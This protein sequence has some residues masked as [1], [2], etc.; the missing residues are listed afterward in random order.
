MLFKLSIIT[1]PFRIHDLGLRI[2]QGLINLINEASGKNELSKRYDS[3]NAFFLEPVHG[4]DVLEEAIEKLEPM[5]QRRIRA[6]EDITI[7]AEELA[8]EHVYDEQPQSNQVHFI[9]G[10]E[11]DDPA[12][13]DSSMV[14]SSQFGHP[15]FVNTNSSAVHL[16]LHTYEGW[17]WHRFKPVWYEDVDTINAMMWTDRL[18]DIFAEN[19]KRDPSI[20]QYF[21]S[22]EGVLRYFPAHRWRTHVNQHDNFDARHRP[23]FTQSISSAKDL[24]ILIDVS[25]SIH[26][27]TFEI[28]KITVKRLL[29]T[30]TQHD[31]FNVLQFN[32]TVAWLL[33]CSES[34]MP[35]TTRNKRLIYQ[36]LDHT[37]PSGKAS[38]AN[39]LNFTY[40]Y[41]LELDDS[42][43]SKQTSGSDSSNC[44]LA[45]VLISDGGTEFPADQ[46]EMIT[47]N[48]VTRQ[49]RLFTLAVGPHPIPTLNL[50][51][52]SCSTNAFHGAI[53]TYGAIQ[54]KVQGY[55]QVLSRPLA[56][57]Q[58]K[59]LISWSL[60]YQD[61][62]GSGTVVTVS[63]PVFHRGE[64]LS[65]SLLGVAG[66]DIPISSFDVALPDS[67]LGFG[68]HKMV[69]MGGTGNVVHHSQLD[70]Q[71]SYIEDPPIVD[72]EDLEP[73]GE[74]S[75]SLRQQLL[76][77]K[78]GSH[79]YNSTTLTPDD[80]YLIHQRRTWH[81][82]PISKTAYTLAVS[83]SEG[84]NIIV[85]NLELQGKVLW[86]N[87]TIT[88]A[89]PWEFCNNLRAYTNYTN[90]RETADYFSQL[91]QRFER[92]GEGCDQS[93]L[94]H[95]LWDLEMTMNVSQM[96]TTTPDRRVHSRFVST[97]GGVTRT[98]T[99][100]RAYLQ[101]DLADPR[102]S[103]LFLRLAHSRDASIL[104]RPP[105]SR[106]EDY[107]VAAKISS[108]EQFLAI[109][110][111]LVGKD[112]VH[113]IWKNAV[114]AFN[115]SDQLHLY[116]LDEGG[117][118]VA[119]N[120]INVSPGTFIGSSN[121]DPQLMHA[122]T[123]DPNPVYERNTIVK[124]AVS[125]PVFVKA[126]SI[127]SASIFAARWVSNLTTTLLG[128]AQAIYSFS[129]SLLWAGV[130][131]ATFQA[132]MELDKLRP[133]R[134]DTHLCSKEYI[135]YQ[136]KTSQQRLFNVSCSKLCAGENSTTR[137]VIIHP[138]SDSSSLLIAATA[139]CRCKASTF[140]HGLARL[141]D[142][143]E[144]CQFHRR[145]HKSS[146]H[147]YASDP[148]E[149]SLECSGQSLHNPALMFPSMI[150]IF[151]VVL[152]LR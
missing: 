114:E 58:D 47:N 90:Q 18:D 144:K 134:V 37:V 67:Q 138:M 150:F 77:R 104:I 82:R 83:I 85:P 117:Y 27:P 147:C 48:S 64:N 107:L 16:P 100:T 54:S 22:K 124:R 7:K 78:T 80:A 51:N 118:I 8:M 135:L 32:E 38:F 149:N 136:L 40:H 69:V 63:K 131:S 13:N 15:F 102:N 98:E 121:A 11:W 115:I 56:L 17:M 3:Q 122:L 94:S 42:R 59:S 125:C 105:L 128:I 145:Y 26:G 116:W 142:E 140:Q 89:A 44:H 146:E 23:W 35:A 74:W 123:L 34:L 5:F 46:V 139:P 86:N 72:Y 9:N 103:S 137:E 132:E 36:A 88:R 12:L 151:F 106:G 50:R 52:I 84:A 57:S 30:L 41:I 28:L 92:G 68:G 91:S 2:S 29:G 119:T 96:W 152:I 79:S 95:L 65:Q 1:L 109:A 76:D 112:I 101:E 143:M 21:A 141:E 75:D 120:Q 81:F 4:E 110:G 49:T 99:R 14:N 19:L 129:A 70:T 133:A 66:V 55:L 60:P 130:T 108:K 39:A 31:Y 71:N 97:T 24:L 126:A 6:V 113:S 62:A 45:V 10:K 73:T 93:A 33:P 127:S 87:Q 43:N 61:A 25:G 111:A 148:R 20:Y 53:L